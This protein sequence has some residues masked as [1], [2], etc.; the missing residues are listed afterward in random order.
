MQV[1]VFN[2]LTQRKEILEPVR[3]GQIGMYVCGPTVYDM[4]H[5]GHARAYVAYDV[6]ARFLRYLGYKVTYV[7]NFTDVD[8][9]IIRKAKALG[10]S[11]QEVAEMFISEFR[12]DMGALGVENPDV[13]PKVTDH[14]PE[15]ISLIEKIV[16]NGMAYVSDGDV[17]F[18]VRNFPEYGK[19]SKRNLDSLEAGA[20]VEPGVR[21]KDPLD[22]VLWKAA[23]PGEPQWDS[24]WGKGRPGWHIECS[25][26]SAKY[27]GE[28]FDI[29]AGGKDL[30]FPHHENEIA[31][32]EAASGKPFVRVWLHNGFV[33]IDNEKM[34]KSLGNFLTVREIVGRFEGET[35]RYFLLGTHYR[36][37]INFSDPLLVDAQKRV[38][39]LYETLAKTD[40]RLEG[41]EKTSGTIL[42]EEKVKSIRQEFFNSLGNDFNTAEALG[43]L[44]EAF[45]LMNELVEKPKSKD[46]ASV[47]RTLFKLREDVGHMGEVLG[48]FQQAPQPFLLQLREKKAREKGIDAQIV[49]ELLNSRQQARQQKDFAAADQ[50]REKLKAMGVELMDTPRGTVWKIP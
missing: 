12:A 18:S 17:Y 25:A 40:Q 20:R 22:F 7:R 38:E 24:P 49:E 48:L 37:P 46:K 32:S 27:L 43:V 14:I 1:S 15:V 35:L 42:E 41:K 13:E 39:Y 4:S 47:T 21:K 8:D 30:V 34:S 6:I 36:N 28:T 33:Q 45:S 16:K 3:E 29:H 5:I 11:S 44:S 19:L 2:T 26:M 23:K 9:N 50:V 31:Q 10:K